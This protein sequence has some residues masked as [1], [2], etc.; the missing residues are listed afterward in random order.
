MFGPTGVASRVETLLA[1]PTDPNLG[2]TPSGRAPAHPQTQVK[3]AKRVSTRLATPVGPNLGDYTKW[4]CSRAPT[5][6]SQGRQK[7]FDLAGYPSRREPRG[8]HHVDELLR[9]H[10][11][12]TRSPKELQPDWLPQSA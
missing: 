9:T 7:S 10:K 5:N 4:T 11:L 3:V 12:K 6:S 2:T 1:T 8:L